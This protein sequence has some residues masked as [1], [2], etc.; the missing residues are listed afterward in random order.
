[1]LNISPCIPS[2]ILKILVLFFSLC[3]IYSLGAWAGAVNCTSRLLYCT[4]RLYITIPPLNKSVIIALDLSSMTNSPI[5]PVEGMSVEHIHSQ[6]QWQV[7]SEVH[8]GYGVG[9]ACIN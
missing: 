4:D 2:P 3:F 1:M 7:L 6:W 8:L 5:N 9:G